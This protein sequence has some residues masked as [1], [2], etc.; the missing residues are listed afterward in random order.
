[1]LCAK[2]HRRAIPLFSS[3]ACDW[4]DGRLERDR[5]AR[6]YVVYGP[7]FVGRTPEL[8]VFP[9]RHHAERW[10]SANHRHSAEIREVLTDGELVW[11]RSTGILD[12][13]VF[14]D[15]LFEIHAD[16]RYPFAPNRAFLA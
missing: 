5:L 9:N 12:D 16:H 3:L 2:C 1:M 13:L 14:A 7:E 11:R 10:R 6:G 8:Y 4:C 15:R